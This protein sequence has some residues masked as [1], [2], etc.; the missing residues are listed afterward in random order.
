M[1]PAWSSDGRLLCFSSTTSRRS[2]VPRT[3]AFLADLAERYGE[4][5]GVYRQAWEDAQWDHQ[6]RAGIIDWVAGTVWMTEG[7]W[8]RSTWSP[9]LHSSAALPDH[10]GAIVTRTSSPAGG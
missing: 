8:R 2:P 3:P 9:V 4:Q 10:S 1:E 5:S 6:H 7:C